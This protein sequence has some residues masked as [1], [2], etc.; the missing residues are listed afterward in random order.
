MTPLAETPEQAARDLGRDVA[1]QATV[2]PLRSGIRQL[3]D[4][5]HQHLRDGGA[6]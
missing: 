4:A 3:L 1:A 2:V 6:A 5:W